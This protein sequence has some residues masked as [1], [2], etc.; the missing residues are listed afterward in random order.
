M[1]IFITVDIA[2]LAGLTRHLAHAAKIV[3][4][5]KAAVKIDTFQNIVSDHHLDQVKSIFMF[6]EGVVLF[7]DKLVAVKQ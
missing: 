6:L 7:A 2:D 1:S 5:H 4:K 3:E